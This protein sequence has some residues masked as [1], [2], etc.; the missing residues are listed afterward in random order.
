MYNYKTLNFDSIQELVQNQINEDLHLDFK[1]VK[2][3]S[4]NRDDRKNLAISLSG[5][6]NSDGG[7]I[8]WGVDARK[9]AEGVD[10]ASAVKLIE[11]F[12]LFKSR[13]INLVTD[14]VNPTVD[15]VDHNFIELENDRGIAITFVPASTSTPHMAKL[16][17]DRYYKRSGDSFIRLE[18][19]DLE[20]M[21]G[22]RQKPQLVLEYRVVEFGNP[23][24]QKGWK[25]SIIFSLKNQ[26]RV[27]AK[28]PYLSLRVHHPFGL[29]PFGIDGNGNEGLKRIA[30]ARDRICW[31]SYG[32]NAG[33]IIH[34]HCT[35]DI[36]SI[37]A[38]EIGPS[39]HPIDLNLLYEIAAE[40][41]LLTSKELT[42]ST[43]DLIQMISDL[44]NR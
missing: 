43:V 23:H 3:P 19:F 18:H 22:R 2:D 10:V 35:L 8:V 38:S 34:P 32:S 27:P 36:C 15:G 42:V 5:F 12:S 20:D 13:L 31:H 26:G 17:E 25:F 30:S 37:T 24:I 6:A 4:I 7:L 1:T 14:A 9:N 33:V 39:S 40:N 21:F 41:Q 44:R 11:S 29:N 28:A 16:G